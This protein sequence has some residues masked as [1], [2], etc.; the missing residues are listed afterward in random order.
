MRGVGGVVAVMSLA[1]NCLAGVAFAADEADAD[2]GLVH[3]YLLFSGFDIWRNGGSMHGGLLWS[4]D[5]LER[6]GLT[7]KL[8]AA[9]GQYRYLAN[10]TPTIGRYALTSAM[11]GWRFKRSDLEA[12]LLVGPDLQSHRLT[13][14]DPDNRQRGGHTGLRVS[15]DVWYQAAPDFMATA[16]VSTS[17]IGASYWSRAAIGWRPFGHA[18]VGP[19]IVAIGGARYRQLRA[20]VHATAFRTESFEWT[21][22]IGYARDS[23][24]R[25]GYYLHFGV[26][27]RR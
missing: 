10:D 2:G 20:G 12:T 23:D 7:F 26:L 13:P 27:T 19:E 4:P 8:L 15:A 3:R 11:A 5:G 22:G 21:A 17:T 16:S 9:G 24:E 25:S 14:D 18:W 1:A 6:E